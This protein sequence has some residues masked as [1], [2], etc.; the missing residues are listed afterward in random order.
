MPNEI[1]AYSLAKKKTGMK[2]SMEM[3]RTRF[4][5]KKARI[6]K[7]PTCISGDGVRISTK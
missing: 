1:W 7:M 4:S 2:A 5:T 6:R 3:P